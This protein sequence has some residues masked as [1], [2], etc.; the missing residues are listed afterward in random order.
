TERG[1]DP[2]GCLDALR[3]ALSQPELEELEQPSTIPAS[4]RACRAA[5]GAAV[6]LG[7]CRLFG[8]STREAEDLNGVLPPR[9]A[10][11]AATALYQFLGEMRRAAEGLAADREPPGQLVEEEEVCLDLLESRMDVWAAF[12]AIDES[13]Q[14]CLEAPPGEADPL[15]E[16]L[17][18]A[19]D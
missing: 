14:D 19:V 7:S 8:V 17:G 1:P 5:F 16:Q 4:E 10:L 15:E 13:W 9:T 18:R 11:A 3:S 12:V 2:A 6:A